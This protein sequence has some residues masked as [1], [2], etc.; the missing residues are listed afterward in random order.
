[1]PFRFGKTNQKGRGS[2]MEQLYWEDFF[3]FSV[4]S[5]SAQGTACPPRQ[6]LCLGWDWAP[7]LG[8]WGERGGPW[9]LFWQGV[10]LW[11]SPD[12][13]QASNSDILLM[14]FTPSTAQQEA[15]R[16]FWRK[17]FCG[18]FFFCLFCFVSFCH[19]IQALDKASHLPDQ[20]LN[21]GCSEWQK[22]WVLTTRPPVNSSYLIS[23]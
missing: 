21:L 13:P 10:W 22:R 23:S 14:T 7:W 5:S 11:V 17:E 12:S 1:M 19:S 20:G 8:Q 16:G 9:I 3:Y 6:N 15:R 18:F 2:R 4:W